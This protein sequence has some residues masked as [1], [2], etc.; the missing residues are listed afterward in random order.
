MEKQTAPGGPESASE[1]LGREAG[2]TL[3]WWATSSAQITGGFVLLYLFLGLFFST[4]SWQIFNHF[5]S[6][7][8]SVT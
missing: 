1:M 3:V 5:S 2:L 8:L 7:G 4:S 6:Q